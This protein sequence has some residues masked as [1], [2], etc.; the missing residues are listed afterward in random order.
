M[1]ISKTP[2]RISFFGGGTDYPAW[3]RREGGA[4]LSTTIDKYCYLSCRHLPPF[5]AIR[6]RVVWSHIETVSSIAEI[7]HPAVREGLRTLGFDDTEGLEIQHQGDLPARAGMGSS[8]AF[9]VGLLN[10]LLTLKGHRADP[11]EL[12]RRAIDL[13]QNVL[14]ENVGSQ[15]QVAAAH[16]GLNFIRFERDGAIDVQPV[17]LPPERIRELESRL[18][19]VYTGESRLGSE[20]AAG[21]V[22]NIASRRAELCEM[23]LLVDRAIDV[24]TGTGSL[25]AFGELF[26][27]GWHLKQTLSDRVSSPI[28]ER[29]YRLAMDNGARGGKLLGAGGAGFLLFYVPPHRR[30]QVQAS[31]SGYLS[32]PFSFEPLGSVIIHGDDESRRAAAENREIAIPQ[33]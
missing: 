17:P 4:V 33:P 2:F 20:I 1:I 14:K 16:G 19:L 8:S 23:R 7:L 10:A 29:V 22:R 9:A 21:V 28:V 11:Q 27:R 26:T 15:D 5:F 30:S 32:V 31:L 25:D 18:M 24:L 12:A 6:H 13:E 3:S